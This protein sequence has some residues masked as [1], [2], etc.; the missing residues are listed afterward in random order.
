MTTGVYTRRMEKHPPSE[1]QVLVT[2]DEAMR[3]FPGSLQSIKRD[4]V[5]PSLFITKVGV[6]HSQGD[7]RLQE[8]SI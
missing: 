6:L 5:K 8:I 3:C 1:I 4:G 7:K 2:E